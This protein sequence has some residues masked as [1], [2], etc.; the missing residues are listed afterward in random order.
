MRKAL[1][2]VEIFNSKRQPQS[3]KQIL[4][5]AKF[6]SI[7]NNE[8]SDNQSKKKVRQCKTE[9]CGLCPILQEHNEIK[10]KNYDKKFEIHSEMDCTV[11]DVIY[12]IR[13]GGCDKEY[14]GETS[15]LRARI[16]VHKQQ[17]LD[18]RLRRLYVSHHIAHCAINK[19][20]LFQVIP[21]FS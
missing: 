21:F 2:D 6:T 20:P 3:L 15:N 16:R 10:F 4:T 8:E 14:I 11:G 18:P 7:D 12:L 9:K 5:R 13:C 1:A 19:R 17:I